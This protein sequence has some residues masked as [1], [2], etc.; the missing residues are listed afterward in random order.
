MDELKRMRA[1]P[2]RQ[3]ETFSLGQQ[4]MWTLIVLILFAFPYGQAVSLL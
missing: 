1:E 2:E 4:E 3:D